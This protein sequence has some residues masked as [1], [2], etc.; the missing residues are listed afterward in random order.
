MKGQEVTQKLSMGFQAWLYFIKF[1][2]KCQM[3]LKVQMA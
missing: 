2:L 1:F 3:T